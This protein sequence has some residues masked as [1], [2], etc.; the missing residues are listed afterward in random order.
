MI[1]IRAAFRRP[2]EQGNE[3]QDEFEGWPELE[4]LHRCELPES[5]G[6]GDSPLEG[7][8]VKAGPSAAPTAARVRLDPPRDIK[9]KA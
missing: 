1:G 7:L 9:P 6:S 8:A 5:V 3:D 2:E 4:H